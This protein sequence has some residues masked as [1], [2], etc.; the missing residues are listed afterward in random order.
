MAPETL[1]E[2]V[3]NV[4]KAWLELYEGTIL[5]DIVLVIIKKAKKTKEIE[6][7]IINNIN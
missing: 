2:S 7:R 6:D 3:E 5:E 4:K 1:K